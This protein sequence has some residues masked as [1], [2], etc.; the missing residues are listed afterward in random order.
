M[1]TLKDAANVISQ[2][3]RIRAWLEMNDPKA[4]E[5]LDQAVATC[6]DEVLL[7]RLRGGVTQ[8]KTAI[9]RMDHWIRGLQGSDQAERLVAFQDVRKYLLSEQ[10]TLTTLMADLRSQG[11]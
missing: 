9:K 1:K 2:S 5:Q 10:E 4:L 7:E 6:D 8:T 11:E 3:P